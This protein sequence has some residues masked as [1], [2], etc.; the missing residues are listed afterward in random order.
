M[1]GA[2]SRAHTLTEDRL[3]R[4]WLRDDLLRSP[5]R[6][7]DG[8]AVERIDPGR[9][10]MG[11]GPDFLGASLRIDGAPVRGD[12]EFHLES[13]G[14]RA[15]RHHADGRYDGVALHL[16]LNHTC[17]ALFVRDSAGRAVP[18]VEL[19]SQLLLPLGDAARLLS[20]EE[21]SGL[22]CPLPRSIAPAER[23][24]GL[25]R[26]SEARFLRKAAEFRQ[27]ADAYSREEAL[28][29]RLGDALG[30]S[31]NRVA[32]AK[33]TARVPLSAARGLAPLESEALFL[34]A[35]DLLPPADTD[36]RC[37]ELHAL[38]GGRQPAMR[39]SEWRTAPL[40][41]GNGPTRRVT[42]LA[43][44]ARR[45]QP[46]MEELARL[47]RGGSAARGWRTRW[48]AFQPAADLYWQAHEEI[49]RPSG[50][51][52]KRL[53]GESRARDIWVNAALPA[54][55]AYAEAQA[56]APLRARVLELYRAHPPLQSNW[57]T[58]WLGGHAL[59]LPK[60]GDRSLSASQQQ[61]GLDLYAA[62]CSPRRC[63]ECPLMGASGVSVGSV[64]AFREDR[65]VY[66]EP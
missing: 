22:E 50:R 65:F 58:R 10:N 37:A 5:L 11:E 23:L 51:V 55:A 3:R 56:D 52:S 14:W 31:E 44:L 35:A 46:L 29:R 45:T 15:H 1:R 64:S 12:V 18:T 66:D 59:G 36:A 27:L 9:W 6:S 30:Y 4:V 53:V 62:Y 57:K 32:F 13:S 40:R 7:V 48:A 47:A 2:R 8:R 49:G 28:Y 42:A 20:E 21:K 60:G 34:G 33:L 61:G 38:W 25:E 24:T 43:A 19:R 63:S 39:R 26:L 17:G 41:R 16:A 54:L